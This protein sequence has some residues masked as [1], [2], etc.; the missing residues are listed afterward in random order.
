MHPY[1][2]VPHAFTSVMLD[3]VPSLA[4]CA[5][6]PRDCRQAFCRLLSLANTAAT[7]EEKRHSLQLVIG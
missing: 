4:S 3:V 7:E 6:T 1:T 5:P 2:N